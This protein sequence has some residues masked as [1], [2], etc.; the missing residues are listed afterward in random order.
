MKG[1]YSPVKTFNQLSQLN[2][3]LVLSTGVNKDE[4]RKRRFPEI[5]SRKY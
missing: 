4:S 5:A 1:K 2:L 3:I